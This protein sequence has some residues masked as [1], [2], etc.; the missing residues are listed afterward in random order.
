M[1]HIACPIDNHRLGNRIGLVCC[2]HLP[3]DVQQHGGRHFQPIHGGLDS[4]GG[5]LNVDSDKFYFVAAQ[6][7]NRLLHQWHGLYAWAAPTGPK[8]QHNDTVE[9]FAQAKLVSPQRLQRKVSSGLPY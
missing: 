9:I 5:F 6:I 1:S 3:V 4:R 7:G 8:V 2:S